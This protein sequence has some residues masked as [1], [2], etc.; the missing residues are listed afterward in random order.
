MIFHEAL[1]GCY[2][3]IVTRHSGWQYWCSSSYTQCSLTSW[4]P[5]TFFRCIWA[6]QALWKWSLTL[7]Y[8]RGRGCS[9]GVLG[10][11]LSYNIFEIK[12][13]F[14]LISIYLSISCSLVGFRFFLF[15]LILEMSDKL[16]NNKIRAARWWASFR[17]LIR[18][19]SVSQ[20]KH[21]TYTKLITRYP[22]QIRETEYIYL[23]SLIY[24]FLW[25]LASHR[26]SY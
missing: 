3:E 1:T 14:F 16:N 2:M 5:G 22:Q 4:I 24:Y 19:L 7:L 10:R 21:H 11:L 15:A 6:I 8:S 13:S 9:N 17:V 20:T 12:E 25:S 23:S 26:I 18:S